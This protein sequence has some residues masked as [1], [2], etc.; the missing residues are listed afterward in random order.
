MIRFFFMLVFLAV[1]FNVEAQVSMSKVELEKKAAEGDPRAQYEL[2]RNYFYCVINAVLKYEYSESDKSTIK[3]FEILEKAKERN[4][5]FD[6][7]KNNLHSNALKCRQREM[8]ETFH[9]ML[10]YYKD[11]P[12]AIEI[13]AILNKAMYKENDSYLAAKKYLKQALD[14]K[15]LDAEEYLDMIAILEKK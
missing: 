7:E 12:N 13:M 4:R 2:G 8:V 11:A 5:L 3:E 6:E 10:Y 9:R 15:Y 14:Q 1:S